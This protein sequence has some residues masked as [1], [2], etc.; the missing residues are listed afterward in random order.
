MI[1]S[2]SNALGITTDDPA[3]LKLLVSTFYKDL[4]ASEGMRNMEG[5]VENRQRGRKCGVH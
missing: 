4:F 3:E 2:L 5:G 1:K